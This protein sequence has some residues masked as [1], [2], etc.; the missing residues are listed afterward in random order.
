[1]SEV[2]MMDGT[3]HNVGKDC[4]CDPDENRK[5]GCG[6]L[7]HYQAVYGGYYYQCDLCKTTS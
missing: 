4:W 5:C 1:M 3:E 7:R 2:F 6:G